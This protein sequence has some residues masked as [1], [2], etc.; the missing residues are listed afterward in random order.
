MS[1]QE[2]NNPTLV[3]RRVYLEPV[4]MAY[5]D[6]K[7]TELGLSTSQYLDLLVQTLISKETK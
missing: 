3:R 6:K 2:F 4:T 7:A 1:K 5:L